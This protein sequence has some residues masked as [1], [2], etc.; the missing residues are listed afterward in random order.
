MLR[1]FIPV[2]AL[3]ILVWSCTPSPKYTVGRPGSSVSGGTPTGPKTSPGGTNAPYTINGI[4][5]VPVE[6]PSAGKKIK[7]KASFYGYNDGFHGKPTSNG[8]TFDMYGLTAAH[9]TWPMNTYVEV[10]NL[11]N[12]RTVIVRI[13]DRGPFVD[14]RIIDLSYGAAK[15]IKMVDTGVQEVEITILR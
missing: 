13:N 9:K 3:L 7:G 11:A 8:E 6:K 12:G 1:R 2:L 15:E 10:K 14:D 4:K 5:Y